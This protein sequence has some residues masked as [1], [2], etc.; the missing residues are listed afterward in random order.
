MSDIREQIAQTSAA[1]TKA[2]LDAIQWDTT[3]FDRIVPRYDWANRAD[4]I[5]RPAC[6]EFVGLNER[7]WSCQVVAAT[8]MRMTPEIA[9]LIGT[10]CP[11]GGA[12][13]FTSIFGV[14]RIPAE[15]DPFCAAFYNCATQRVFWVTQLWDG[16][17]CVDPI[18][19]SELTTDGILTRA[20]AFAKDLL[21]WEREH[22][23]V[24]VGFDPYLRYGVSS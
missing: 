14:I 17:V 8:E 10:Y 5:V 18:A 23:P 9:S 6:V 15:N 21:S 13:R 4:A 7:S 3:Y 12:I 24:A 22:P 16:A 19:L 2:R 11:D 1:K 20:N